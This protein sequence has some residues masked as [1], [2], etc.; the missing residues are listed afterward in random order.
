M[1]YQ[2]LFFNISVMVS[3]FG[4][5]GSMNQCMVMEW[6]SSKFMASWLECAPDAANTTNLEV[7]CYA[8]NDR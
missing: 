3:Q 6:S 5:N 7:K 2:A 8:V 1:L 4:V